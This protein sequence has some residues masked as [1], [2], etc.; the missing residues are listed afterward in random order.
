M[1][2]KPDVAELPSLISWNLEPLRCPACDGELALAQTKHSPSCQDCGHEFLSNNGLPLLFWPNEWDVRS[3]VTQ[4]VKA[5]YEENSF[6]NYED[7]DSDWSLRDA[8]K[9]GIFGRLLDEQTPRNANVLEVG[10]G[11]GQLGNFMGMSWGRSVFGADLC[12]N[13]LSL[14]H[15]F[16]PSHGI[17]STAFL[18]MNLFRPAFR[19]ESFDLVVCNGVLHHTSDPELGFRSIA[20]S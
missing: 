2:Q 16:K 11:T 10:C 9:R 19:P 13:S 1:D 17:D 18:Q 15:R 20:N 5:F 8:A 3:D 4:S 14:G 12:I 7:I 6:P